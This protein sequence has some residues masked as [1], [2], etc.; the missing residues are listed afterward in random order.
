[1]RCMV[2]VEN[3]SLGLFGWMGIWSWVESDRRDIA[4]VGVRLREGDGCCVGDNPDTYQSDG[5]G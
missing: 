2:T 3:T 5:G 1:M 4:V